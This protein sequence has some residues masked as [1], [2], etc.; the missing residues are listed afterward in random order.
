MTDGKRKKPTIK[1]VAQEAGVSIATVS[2]VLKG[3]RS[4]VSEATIQK[5]LATIERLGYV[6]NLTASSLSSRR[7]NMI[8]V[9]IVGAFNPDP[10][11]D[12]PEINPFYGEFVFRLEHEARS[13]GYTLLL[14][15]GREEKYVNFLLQR[16]VD[17]A[18]LVGLTRVDLRGVIARH[19][20][21][22]IL[23][24]GLVDDDQVMNV[25][26]NEERGGEIS[27]Q[28]LVA[29]GR[30]RLAFLGD[31]PRNKTLIPS[32]RYAGARAACE[33]AGVPLHLVSRQTS[34]EDGLAAAGEIVERKID[35]VVTA[36]DV[37][38]AGLI[39]G[40]KG[41]NLRVPED[42]AVIG[43]D[44]LLISKLVKPML[45]T[46]DQ[47]LDDKIQAVVDLV[48]KGDPGELRLIEPR[49]VVRESA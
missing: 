41:A 13:R 19:D 48:E 27:V 14:Y 30:R 11:K 39:Q 26:T 29:K 38:A 43:Y 21:P 22:L 6:K 28:H 20:I 25:R 40:L 9:I 8:G 4:E 16:N 17:A 3:K 34:F 33:K 46:I 47:G 31:V 2:N 35:G 37:L 45:T 7:S 44:N 15:A 1:D 24:D 42:V 32:L 23:F 49:L 36:A 5:I 18:V 10:A 12:T